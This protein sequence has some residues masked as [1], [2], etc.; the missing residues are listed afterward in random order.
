MRMPHSHECALICGSI[1]MTLFK[2]TRREF[3]EGTAAGLTMAGLG[4]RAAFAAD[5]TLGIVY[6]GPRDDFG[7]NQAH[8]LPVKALKSLPG[9]KAVEAENL[10]QT[11][12]RSNSIEAMLNPH[13]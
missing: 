12:P 3:L 5:I 8:A 11:D 2:I 13:R 7:W 10:P 4:G 1:L 9:V 6:V